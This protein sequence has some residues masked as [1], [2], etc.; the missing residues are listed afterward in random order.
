MPTFTNEVT[1]INNPPPKK[2]TQ[3]DVIYFVDPYTHEMDWGILEE[4]YTD[5][6]WLNLYEPRN[7]MT[8]NDI[9]FSDFPFNHTRKKLPKNW[10]Y[11]TQFYTVG[12]D[13]KWEKIFKE[14]T[15]NYQPETLK[16]LI[17]IGVFVQPSSQPHGHIDTDVTKD[18][19]TIRLKSEYGDRY[20]PDSAVV[21]DRD[22]YAT[23][24]EAKQAVQAYKDELIRQ[25]NLSDYEW[26][27]EQIDK[28]LARLTWKDEEYK[29][30]A[31]EFLLKQKNVEDIVV[32]LHAEGIEWKYDRN[33]KW[34][35]VL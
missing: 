13:P 8:I 11:D 18:G 17:D 33:K 22:A 25:A 34:L 16:H 15:F 10:A 27:V 35:Y 24:E 26:A 21:Q 19:Y 12:S 30:S 3:G 1:Y 7:I 14:E 23:A 9:P 2:Y 28:A 4:T 29:T 20:R 5:G 32:R 31:R 6:Y